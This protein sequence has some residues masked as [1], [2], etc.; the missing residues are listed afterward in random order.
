MANSGE[1]CLVLESVSGLKRGAFRENCVS[2]VGILMAKGGSDKM[3]A[4]FNIKRLLFRAGPWI[5]LHLISAQFIESNVLGVLLLNLK[6]CLNIRN[7]GQGTD[8]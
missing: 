3:K 5:L 1:L 7:E 2:L 6:V 4:V 8:Q